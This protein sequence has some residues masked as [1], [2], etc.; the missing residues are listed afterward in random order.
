MGVTDPLGGLHRSTALLRHGSRW[1]R[2]VAEAP[3]PRELPARVHPVAH[4]PLLLELDHHRRPGDRPDPALLVSGRIRRLTLELLV[5]RA[6]A[7]LLHG[8]E[9][10]PTAGPPAA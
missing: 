1:V 2:L 6:A 10:G 3:Q 9:P 4:A 5:Q 8:R 7:D